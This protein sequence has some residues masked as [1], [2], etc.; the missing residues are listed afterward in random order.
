[1]GHEVTCPECGAADGP[2]RS[3][4]DEL[5]ALEFE[6]PA[7]A[8]VHPLTVATYVLQHSSKLTHEGCLSEWGLLKEFLVENK[9]PSGVRAERKEMLDS[10]K[11]DYKIKSRDGQLVISRS[12]WTKTILAV[13]TETA[14]QYCEDMTAWSRSV[15]EEANVIAA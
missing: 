5:L 6:D 14:A 7:H 9:L 13:R 11:R 2:C 3:R 15:L 8:A 12:T 10:S 1:V 4:F